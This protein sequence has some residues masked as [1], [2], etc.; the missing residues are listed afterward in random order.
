M[1]KL[2]GTLALVTMTNMAYADVD[3]TAM[4][5]QQNIM[6][7]IN[8]RCHYF[9]AILKKNINKSDLISSGFL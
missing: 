2:M 6:N 9:P 1:K 5:K 4:H 8:L 7:N 3:M